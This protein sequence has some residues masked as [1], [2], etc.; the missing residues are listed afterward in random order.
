MGEGLE[1]FSL[2]KNIP[3]AREFANKYGIYFDD[4]NDILYLNKDALLDEYLEQ[5]G[6]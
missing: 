3:K 2:S 1:N 5:I 4:P 6:K